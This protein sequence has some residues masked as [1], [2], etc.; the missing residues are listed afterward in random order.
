MKKLFL[1]LMAIVAIALTSCCKDET[2]IDPT[3]TEGTKITALR[4]HTQT[5]PNP[6]NVENCKSAKAEETL[7]SLRCAYGNH[8]YYMDYLIENPVASIIKSGDERYEYG[9]GTT[10]IKVLKEFQDQLFKTPYPI[11]L[12][13]SPLACS[14]FVC[15]NTKGE[16]L[17]GRNMDSKVGNIVVLFHKNP[18]PGEYKFV[19][20]SNTHYNGT[21]FGKKYGEDGVFLDGTSNLDFLLTNTVCTLDGMNEKGLVYTTFQLPAFQN[22]NAP[23]G[24]NNPFPVNQDKKKDKSLKQLPSTMAFVYT[25]LAKCATVKEVEEKLKNEY[26]Y[27]AL[28]F[29]LNVHWMIADASGDNAIFEYWKDSLYVL[30]AEERSLIGFYTKSVVPYEYN[31]MENYYYNIEAAS[32]YE[33]DA[34]QYSFSTKR[35]AHTM[36]SNYLPVMDEFQA[37]KCLQ[38]GCYG[39]EFPDEVTNYS[40]VYN[41]VQRTMLFNVRNDM[42]NAFTI[43]LKKEL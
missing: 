8:L 28:N 20:F 39:I 32:T 33:K 4:S 15:K 25:I 7:K 29:N 11:V 21:M 18:Q 43:D 10:G 3:I 36:M 1:A 6:L 26:D 5:S 42:T 40:C 24:T 23:D 22:P 17:V 34:W 31:S 16:L 9:D 13:D 2:P 38:Y 14:G 41:P 27:T 30:R 19:A 35:R 37:L 12:F